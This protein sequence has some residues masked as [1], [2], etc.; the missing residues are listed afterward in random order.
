[1]ADVCPDDPAAT[2]DSNEGLGHPLFPRGEH[3]TG[4]DKRRI[5]L[6]QID[7]L[8]EDGT[9][10]HCPRYFKSSE[11]RSWQDIVERFGGG[12]YRLRALCG[13]TYQ[14][15]GSTERREFFGPPTRPMAEDTRSGQKAAGRAEIAPAL[16]TST[17]SPAQPAPVAPGWPPSNGWPWGAPQNG[18]SPEILA[19]LMKSMERSATSPQDPIMAILLKGMMD[20]QATIMKVAFDRPAAPNPL[21]TLQHLKP[22]LESTNG[23][24]QLIKGVE[25]AKS[26]HGSS[27]AAAPDQGEDML[28]MITQMFSKLAPTAA[29]AL[30]AA[31]P[32]P[33]PP[34]VAALPDRTVIRT[35]VRDP[36][37][38]K[39]LLDE[40]REQAERAP[41]PAP[42][43]PPSGA[44]SSSSSEPQ[45][46][47]AR[48]TPAKAEPGELAGPGTTPATVRGDGSTTETAPTAGAF[49]LRSMPFFNEPEFQQVLSDSQPKGMLEALDIEQRRPAAA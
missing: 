48:P 11:I 13:K 6:L 40:L 12:S 31:P 23:V 22:L 14:F 27:P 16:P 28:S 33:A 20:Q 39:Q 49:G 47:P 26:L 29:S 34:L 2:L 1:M 7:R 32:L 18:I 36:E 24:A 10:E 17:P 9:L 46:T 3:E 21:E 42:T 41:R 37:L 45:A 8:R 4:P 19:L 30:P 43:A 25:L 44:G 35:I 5:D 38:R 15:Q